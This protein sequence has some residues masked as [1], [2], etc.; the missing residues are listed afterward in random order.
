M[1]PPFEGNLR[2]RY[3]WTMDGYNLYW[4]VGGNHIGETLSQIG[5]VSPFLMPGYTTYDGSVGIEKGDWN[6]QLY[7]QNLSNN[8]ASAYTSSYQI[9]LAETTLRPRVLGFRFGYRF[10]GK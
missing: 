5:N 6:V 2:V 4:Q 10:S 8:L 9:V 7:G 3:D 1:S